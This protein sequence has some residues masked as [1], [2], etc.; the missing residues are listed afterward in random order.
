MVNYQ[1]FPALLFLGALGLA[2]V[3]GSKQVVSR[4]HSKNSVRIQGGKVV[5]P[6]SLPWQASLYNNSQ[7]DDDTTC[8]GTIICKGLS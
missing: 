1:V 6:H 8:G 4:K 3:N 2:L 5:V 7:N